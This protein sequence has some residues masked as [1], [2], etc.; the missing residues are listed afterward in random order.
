MGEMWNREDIGRGW[1][2]TGVS[3]ENWEGWQVCTSYS[4]FLQPIT[5]SLSFATNTTRNWSLPI[6]K[7]KYFP[8]AKPATTKS[9]TNYKLAS[10]SPCAQHL[11]LL[12]IGTANEVFCLRKGK[13]T[14]LHLRMCNGGFNESVDCRFANSQV[15]ENK[16]HH[17][18]WT[19]TDKLLERN[20]P[21]KHRKHEGHENITITWKT[22][23]TRL[24]VDVFENDS[25]EGYWLFPQKTF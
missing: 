24:F 20:K 7:V 14:C 17:V 18:H 21:G 6:S 16:D 12:T 1:W 15:A 2:K 23:V 3:W 4:C 22:I 13:V 9:H 8:P 5:F 25:S 11:A 10:C 19:D